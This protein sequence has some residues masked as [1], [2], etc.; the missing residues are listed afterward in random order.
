MFS[1][2]GAFFL[3]LLQIDSIGQVI[4]NQAVRGVRLK[5]SK[6]SSTSA[7]ERER[8]PPGQEGGGRDRVQN[9]QVCSVM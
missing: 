1:Y 7:A 5:S 2:F 3:S 9:S 6:L 8:Q 4:Q